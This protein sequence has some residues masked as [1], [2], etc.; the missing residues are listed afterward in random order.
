MATETT[1]DKETKTH[2]DAFD[3]VRAAADYGID[4]AQLRDNLA[5]PV[6]ERLRRHQIALNTVEKLQKAGRS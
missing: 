4:V 5:L 6:A 1:G 3:P 2:A